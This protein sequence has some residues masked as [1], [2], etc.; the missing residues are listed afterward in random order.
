MKTVSLSILAA[1]GALAAN[2]EPTYT[3]S[4]VPYST[5]EPSLASISAAQATVQPLSPTSSV[6][7]LA[8]DRIIQIWLE[9]TNYNVSAGDSS[10]QWLASQGILLTN[11]FA[12]THPSEP[13]YAAV[14]AGDTFGLEN[15]DFIR[16]PAN[17]STVVDLLDTKAISW[18]EYQEHLP[19]AGF[20]GFNYSNQ[21]NFANDYVRKHNPL[22]LFDSVSQNDTRARQIK[23]F[24]SFYDD[25]QAKTLPQ[26]SFITPNM[27]NDAHDTNITFAGSW[28]RT[29][30]EPL[31]SNDYFTNN[32]LVIVSFDENEVYTDPNR[33]YTVLLGGAIDKSLNGTTDDTF[34][35]HYTTISTVS[36]NW[37]LP[38]LGRWDCD[39]NVLAL[40]AN[41][42][43]YKN[44]DV[45]LNGLFF[46]VS[47]PGPVSDSKNTPGWWPAPDTLAKCTTG[48][49]VLP[50]IAAKWGN[51]TGTYNYTNVYPYDAGSHTETGGT[52]V[53]GN[54]DAPS[55][56]SSGSPTSTTGSAASPSKTNAAAPV[57]VHSGVM[58]VL[59]L[60]GVV[61]GLV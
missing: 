13:N 60:M 41:K 26:W 24:V 4:R 25:L 36:Q 61:A 44:A 57:E 35:N 42:T 29:F 17:I 49:G 54:A 53:I 15:D 3:T 51:S 40:V 31:L 37:D 30:L 20:Q 1:A 33:V 6:K 23:S 9:N 45:S 10:M 52:P 11:Y 16:F 21:K 14:V 56:S 22:I 50:A 19:Y 2:S 12:V 48:K 27:S 7:G 47:Y 46:N 18:G 39:A 43:G 55:S 32:T 59:G 38:S 28:T 5:I 34:Y 58:A 8:F